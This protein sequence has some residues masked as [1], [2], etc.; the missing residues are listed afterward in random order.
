MAWLDRYGSEAPK[1][2]DDMQGALDSI[3]AGDVK[4]GYAALSALADSGYG[5]AAHFLGW[6]HRYRA[7]QSLE[8]SADRFQQAIAAGSE[9]SELHLQRTQEALRL[10]AYPPKRGSGE[11]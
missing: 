10:V 9:P 5:P 4:S 8:A 2:E 11:G 1:L 3:R 7:E 6:L